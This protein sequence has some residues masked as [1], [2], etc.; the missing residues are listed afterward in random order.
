MITG[1]IVTLS[2]LVCLLLAVAIFLGLQMIKKLSLMSRFAYVS[3]TIV[4]WQWQ[5]AA[6]LNMKPH[7]RNIV[8]RAHGRFTALVGFRLR[9]RGIGSGML[10]YYEF[11]ESDPDGVA[12]VQTYCG[13]N[14]CTFEFVVGP[15]TNIEPPTVSSTEED[16]GLTP[17]VVCPPHWYQKWLGFYG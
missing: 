11:V 5:G 7:M 12:V 4:A 16:Q 2:L 14:P 10:D 9:I 3:G 13:R 17:K 15:L 1:I 8:L 6:W